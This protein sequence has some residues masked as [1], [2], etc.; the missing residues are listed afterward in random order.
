MADHPDVSWTD[1]SGATVADIVKGVAVGK[2]ESRAVP[3]A[4]VD[5]IKADP[6]YA[7]KVVEKNIAVEPVLDP[8]MDA[9]EETKL[10]SPPPS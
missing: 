7:G 5:A 10:E 9:V 1:I 6:K 3:Q 4:K 8:I 2:V